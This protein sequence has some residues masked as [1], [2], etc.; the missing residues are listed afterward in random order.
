MGKEELKE[1]VEWLRA[2]IGI[3]FAVEVEGKPKMDVITDSTDS[4]VNKYLES[5]ENETKSE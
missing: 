3:A 2:D 4:I 5:L 1:F